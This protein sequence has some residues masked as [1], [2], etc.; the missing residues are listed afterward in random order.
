VNKGKKKKKKLPKIKRQ[1]PHNFVG[2]ATFPL[3]ALAPGQGVG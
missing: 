3:S 2:S 1:V